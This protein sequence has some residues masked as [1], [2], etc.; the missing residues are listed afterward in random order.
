M[1]IIVT[2]SIGVGKTTVCRKVADLSKS[3]GHSCGGVLSYKAPDGGI[4]VVDVS[5]ERVERLAGAGDLY[6]GPRVGKYHFSRAGIDF[7]NLAIDRGAA[8]DI[9]FVDEVGPLEL[10]GKGFVK[11]LELLGEGRAQRCVTVVRKELLPAFS[12]RLGWPA[13]VLET[14][15]GNR[16]ELPHI[17]CSLLLEGRLQA[18]GGRLPLTIAR[19]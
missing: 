4:M 2:G 9:L 8:S 5:T 13:V 16:D 3:A 7:G 1:N 11:A 14:T 19:G 12:T 10:A 17:I 6:D 18:G 15:S